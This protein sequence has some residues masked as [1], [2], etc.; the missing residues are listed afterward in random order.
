MK[1]NEYVSPEMEVVEI[2]EKCAILNV[3]GENTGGEIGDY[4]PFA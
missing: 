2:V 1:K 4:D 3:S